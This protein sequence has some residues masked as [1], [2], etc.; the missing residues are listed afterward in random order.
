MQ[1]QRSSRCRWLQISDVSLEQKVSYEQHPK[2]FLFLEFF[3]ICPHSL[4]A[5][6]TMPRGI[7]LT[8]SLLSAA[9][10]LW[11]GTGSMA[12]PVE[13]PEEEPVEVEP[14]PEP[15]EALDTVEVPMPEHLDTYIKNT[16]AAIVLGKALFWDTQ[17]GSDGVVACA[18]CHWHAGADA[19]TRNTVYSGAPGGAF[20][21]EHP[22][23]E[24]MEEIADARFHALG[25]ANQ[26]LKASHFP[27]H[28][29]KYPTLK[30]DFDNPVISDNPEI[31]GSQGVHET[32][33]LNINEGSA[34]DSGTPAENPEYHVEGVS[35]R[36]VTARNT[37]T[38]IN[39]IFND[40]QFW[41]GRAQ[42]NFNGVNP[43]GDLDKHA[44]VYQ[45]DHS[46]TLDDKLTVIFE[47]YPWAKPF[48]SIFRR[49]K[50]I[51]FW[52]LP[53]GF[54]G[55]E[56]LEP[57]RIN[58]RHASLASQAVGPTNNEVEMSFLGRSFPEVG[59]KM[60]SLAPLAQQEVHPEDSVLGQYANEHGDGLEVTYAQLVRYAFQDE[61][62]ASEELTDDGFT[63][64]EAN[65]SLYWGLSIMM[66]ESTLVSDDSPFD[67]FRQG[68]TAALS[69]AALR[70]MDTFMGA[71]GCIGCHEGSEFTGASH[72]ATHHEPIEFMTMA[73]E[74]EAFYDNGFYNIGVRPTMEDI[75]V[76]ATHP[77]FG[78]LSYS[79]RQQN[80]EDLDSSINV[81]EGARTSVLGSFKTPGLRN[82]ELTG[83][84]MHHGG[85]RTL[86]EVVQFYAR[87]G[88]FSD[89]NIDDLDPDVGG[90]EELQGNPHGIA[91]LVEFMKA[92]TDERVR[93]ERAPFDHPSLVI[94]NGH[95]IEHKHVNM[96][97][98][99]VDDK[100][101]HD[102][103][104]IDAVGYAGR[105]KPIVAFD[106]I[107]VEED[108]E[109]EEEE[110]VAAAEEE[111]EEE[112]DEA[113]LFELLKS[114]GGI[115]E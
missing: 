16:D 26:V 77:D 114:L 110:E 102:D 81:P 64:M 29:V 18:S 17:V 90:V 52:F 36:Q 27:T 54:Q 82:V 69:D 7:A 4:R 86:T 11:S 87:G 112:V 70:G 48:E 47:A 45:R 92:L 50:F 14:A 75:G 23:Q 98:D 5:W 89:E 37:P 97:E 34:V 84:Y 63:H 74:G 95:E 111:E 20:G 6:L 24:L 19:R 73:D 96:A 35:V 12:A 66:Y 53:Y 58:I 62:W 46:N 28:K 55:I 107:V 88:D 105:N 80:G 103:F 57:V 71:G 10:L 99:I 40:R 91:D 22:G 32:E 106:Q 33:F 1:N 85:M 104:E 76:G 93:Y 109:E 79:K 101:S 39:A 25:R 61:W 113:A 94:V 30:K 38:M 56:S 2:L 51:T 15:P 49:Y 31:V 42:N 83:P 8:L 72:D 44:R 59:R 115:D 65:F 78:P 67:Q 9:A 68:K 43:F 13:P 3:M 100:E 21:P 41:D 60:F 108:K